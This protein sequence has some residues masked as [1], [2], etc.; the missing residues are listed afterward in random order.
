MT[1][2]DLTRIFD[3]DQLEILCRHV[4]VRIP[5]I[6]AVLVLAWLAHRIAR[7]LVRQLA[8]A[9]EKNL[10]P[11]GDARLAQRTRTMTH[12]ANSLLRAAVGFAAVLGLMAASGIDVGPL[13]A[14]AGVVGIS[15]GL[16]AQN[17]IKDLIA[18][19][20]ILYEDQFGVGDTIEIDGRTGTVER[21]NFRI[22][23]IR[24]L[25]GDLVTIPNG[26]IKVVVNQ[27]NAWSRAILELTVPSDSDANQVLSLMTEAARAVQQAWPAR[28]WSDPEVVG[29]QSFTEQGMTLRLLLKTGPQD[30][31]AV[32]AEWRRHVKQ[33]LDEAGI[34]LPGQTRKPGSGC[35][36]A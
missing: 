31:G 6:L 29:I 16:G 35:V 13:L 3:T 14:S 2:P 17:L 22:T 15:V 27:S 8:Q 26:Q 4:A 36:N 34:A 28:V 5:A 23:R 19:F 1:F 20:A 11:G 24:T 21:L 18:G 32:A 9:L 12:M 10:L 30:R 25:A 33:A 7:F